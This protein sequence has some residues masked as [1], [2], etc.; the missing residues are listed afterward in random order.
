MFV[1]FL[2]KHTSEPCNILNDWNIWIFAPSE[3]HFAP[4]VPP[5]KNSGATTANPLR[6]MGVT[7]PFTNTCKIFQAPPDLKNSGAPFYMYHAKYILI[8]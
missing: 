7:G 3:S 5:Q 6:K 8:S 1:I 2:V 4:S